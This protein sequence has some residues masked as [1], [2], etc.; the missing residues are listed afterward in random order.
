MSLCSTKRLVRHGL[1]S[2]IPLGRVGSTSPLFWGVI[3]VLLG[4]M[5]DVVPGWGQTSLADSARNLETAGLE[6]YRTGTYEGLQHAV[7]LW[8]QAAALQLQLGAKEHYAK[9]LNNLGL[10]RLNLGQL[11]RARE[12]LETALRV[13]REVSDPER[14]VGPLHA[15]GDIHRRL[16][17][18][19]TALSYY[20]SALST[21]RGVPNPN[22]SLEATVI[23][24]L[25]ILYAE[26]TEY[27]KAI[28]MFEEAIRIRE[29]LGDTLRIAGSLGN[30][31]G[32]YARVGRQ[33]E[34]AA[35]YRRILA[36]QRAQ[37]QSGGDEVSEAAKAV[38]LTYVNLGILF[39]AA[40]H[41]DSAFSYYRR[42]LEAFRQIGSPEDVAAS[43]YSIAGL[44][45]SVD[46]LPK[47]LDYIRQVREIQTRSNPFDET[48]TLHALGVIFDRLNQQD[49]A[50][51][52]Y[53]EAV[54]LARLRHDPR[55][56]AAGL[57]ALGQLH[58]K[59]LPPDRAKAVAY[60]DSAS[61]AYTRMAGASGNDPNRVGLGE[62]SGLLFAEWAVEWLNRT[63]EVGAS[64][65]GRAALM[66]VERGRA[67][68]LLAM[69]TP[70][71]NEAASLLDLSRKD[72]L[73]GA[74]SLIRVLNRTQTAAL[75]FLA[76]PDS[77]VIWSI[78][79]KGDVYAFRYPIPQARIDT[80][81]AAV[82]LGIRVEGPTQEGVSRNRGEEDPAWSDAIQ[83]LGGNRER[84]VELFS[85]SPSALLARL[86][87]ILLPA[88]VLASLPAETEL[89]LL[90]HG[91]LGLV[92]FAAL[93]IDQRG[94]LLGERFPIR[95][96]PSLS[97]LAAVEEKPSRMSLPL[98]PGTV[99]R[100][101]LVVG[102]PTMPLDPA[103][104]MAASYLPQLPESRLEAAQ[105]AARLGVSPLLGQAATETIVRSRLS[106]APL[107][108]LATHGLAY[109]GEVRVRDSYVALAP[110]SSAPRGGNDGLLTV[111]EIL[112]DASISLRAELI[113]L[114]ACQTGLG[115]LTEAEG[116]LGF[117]RALLGKGARSVLV[118]LWNVDE[119]ATRILIDRFY[120][121]WLEGDRG[122]PMSKAEALRRAQTDLRAQPG[123]DSPFYW[124]GF[125]VVGAR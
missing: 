22:R 40:A 79:P 103:D 38:A 119:T 18:Y 74:D 116:T 27:N 108:H 43:L 69:L 61:S 5:C 102:D 53:R 52:Y 92:P 20:R 15:L 114:S 33:S 95:V 110:D 70:S 65:A 98:R 76:T 60:Y 54:R 118:S 10:A 37:Q 49:S 101:A 36:I 96:A 26:T 28:P 120:L 48:A 124:A 45:V 85:E 73:S 104:P 4:S 84:V 32:I 6:R 82:R 14:T 11:S 99:V 81:I 100:D 19:N 88:E 25:G 87:S 16:G 47:A 2:S 115:R 46:S 58:T 117:Q 94:T 125:Q 80:L 9:L 17:E 109:G 91:M 23:N 50:F 121:H 68:A 122:A 112:E 78:L 35:L 55:S 113:V 59:Q 39:E 93:P 64:H 13:S 31:A 3:L 106:Q 75:Y 97:T 24:S 30:M 83:A 90:P 123:F 51:A 7:L 62:Q 12:T 86:G 63:D 44:Y 111:G 41:F 67:Q 8:E 107:I 77:L 56:E 66:A 71:S 34:A 89:V 42:S 1:G 105:V 72:L 21:I 57:H 29:S